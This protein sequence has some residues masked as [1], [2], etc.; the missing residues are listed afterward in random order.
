MADWKQELIKLIHPV[1]VD[2]VTRSEVLAREPDLDALEAIEALDLTNDSRMLR[3]EHGALRKDAK[4]NQLYKDPS[5]RELRTMIVAMTD[6]PHAFVGKL[7]RDDFG[8]IAGVIV[9][10]LNGAEA[11][12]VAAPAPAGSKA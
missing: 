5:L 11:E 8:K 4:N 2:G 10:L 12:P 9:P 7:H 1:T 3:D 6:L